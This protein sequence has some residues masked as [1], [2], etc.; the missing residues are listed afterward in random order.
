MA[1][2]WGYAE[3]IRVLCA[4]EFQVSI[5]ESFHAELKAAIASE[6]WLEAAY[7]VGKDYLRGSNGTEFIFRGL[8]RNTQSIK[9]LAQIDLTIVEEAEDVPEMSWL[10]LEATVFRQD[11]SELWALWNPKLPGS[12]VDKRFR[13][14]PPLNGIIQEVNWSDNPFFPKALEELRQRE[15]R[16]LD[17]GTYAHVW[18][19]EYLLDTEARVFR[20][21]QVDDFE[22]PADATFYLGADWGFS[23][24]PTVLVRCFIEDRTLYFDREV[25]QVGC[26]IDRTPALFDKLVPGDDGWARKWPIRAD[27]ARP[28]T[29][30]YMRRHGYE[31]ITSALKGPNSVMDGIE[32]MR[33]YDIV[34]HPRCKHLIDEL[35]MY[36]FKTDPLTG[37]VL[38]VL[39]DKKNHVIDAARYALEI[40][41][42]GPPIAVSMPMRW[43]S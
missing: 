36:S 4:R 26:E 19:G 42:R 34:V 32:F 41:R 21:W 40:I 43:G 9:S 14:N 31:R 33:S 2:V 17:P 35:T 12:P 11:K 37:D 30:S 16:R 5:A 3:P 27:S 22:T 18:E 39:E 6:P 8:R 24:D 25:Y 28:E 7:E 10:A 23:V 20:N 38:P 13:Q 29:I 15:L 1:A